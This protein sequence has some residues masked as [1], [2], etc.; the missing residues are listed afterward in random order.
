MADNN[1]IGGVSVA[2]LLGAIAWLSKRLYDSPRQSEIDRVVKECDE[3]IAAYAAEADRIRDRAD[4]LQAVIDQKSARVESLLIQR[5]AD[6]RELQ[7]EINRLHASADR[8][9]A[10]TTGRSAATIRR[11]AHPRQRGSQGGGKVGPHS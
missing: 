6:N 4:A 8:L 2:A 1:T 11:T 9:L 7:I 10:G 3:R 5:E